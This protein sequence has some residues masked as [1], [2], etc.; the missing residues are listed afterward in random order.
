MAVIEEFTTERCPNCPAAAEKLHNILR[1]PR[2]SDNVVAVCHHSGFHTDWLTIPS[3]VEY[4]WFYNAGGGTYAP[5]MMVDRAA[6]DGEGSAVF[7]V[8]TQSVIEARLDNRL[9]LPTPLSVNVTVT[10]NPDKTASVRVWGERVAEV[11]EDLMVTVYI[12]ENDVKARS[13]AGSGDGYMHQHVNRAVNATWGEP[14]VW[15]GDSYS[16]EYTARL[17]DEWNRS[18]MEA[19]AMVGRYEAD[20]ALGCVVE[21]AGSASFSASGIAGSTSDSRTVTALYDARGM[22]LPEPPAEGFYI[23]V[24]SDGTC[25]KRMTGM[26]K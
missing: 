25:E 6:V 17:N 16:Y 11:P 5:A 24:Y 23:V 2:Y 22:L 8:P 1:D 9:A 7:S 19:V 18:N 15:N 13:Q 12:V 26:R 3:D 14:L 20:N 21:N 10:E 4:Q